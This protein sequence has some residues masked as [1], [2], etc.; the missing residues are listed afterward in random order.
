MLLSLPLFI[1]LTRT[2]IFEAITNEISLMKIILFMNEYFLMRLDQGI[3][4]GCHVHVSCT[5]LFFPS[6]FIL[7][8]FIN[9]LLEQKK[10]VH[11]ISFHLFGF[12]RLRV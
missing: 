9:F 11:F 10:L 5:G 3:R 8:Y 6:L 7:F 2:F 12:I 4:G 1:D